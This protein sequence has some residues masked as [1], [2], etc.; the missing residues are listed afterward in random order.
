M[1]KALIAVLAVVALALGLNPSPDSHR[2][3]LKQAVAERS[4][5]AGLLGIGH[6]AAFASEY[7]TVGV[8]SY[9]KVGSRVVTVGAF[10][11]V[12]VPDIGAQ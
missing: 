1:L 11:I 6:L 10:G 3:K 12:F 2:A 9:S 5:L 4:Q 8:A 7:H